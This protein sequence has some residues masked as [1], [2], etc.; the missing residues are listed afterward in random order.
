MKSYTWR[1]IKQSKFV[2]YIHAKTKYEA[3]IKSMMEYGIV[4]KVEKIKHK[5][6]IGGLK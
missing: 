2:G 6:I 3:I 5:I 4:G 1:V